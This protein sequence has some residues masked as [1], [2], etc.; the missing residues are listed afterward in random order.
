MSYLTC[1][2]QLLPEDCECRNVSKFSFKKKRKKK[3]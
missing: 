3:D 1:P 2:D